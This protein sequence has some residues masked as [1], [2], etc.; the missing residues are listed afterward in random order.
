MRPLTTNDLGIEGN[1]ED[2]QGTFS[3]Q[4]GIAIV[5]IDFIQ[6]DIK[7]PFRI[8]SNL[9][10]RAI[11]SGASK[12]RIEATVVN[13]KLYNALTKRYGMKTSGGI[14]TIEITFKK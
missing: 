10:Q 4:N 7:N 2:I 9:Q 8:L 14:D 13:E 3:M 5:K 6:G 12:L 1:I 11:E